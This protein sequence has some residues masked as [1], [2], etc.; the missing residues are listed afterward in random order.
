MATASPLEAD[1]PTVI[2][3][4][5]DFGIG[6]ETS[7]GIV[8]AHLQGPVTCTSVM[9]T[10]PDALAAST[11][12]LA[13][14]PRLELGLHFVCSGGG[15]R[16]LVA[17]RASGFVG[18][19]GAFLGLATL[20]GRVLAGRVDSAAAEDEMAAQTA[21]FVGAIGR[22]PAYVDGHHHAHQLGPMA[23]A[24]VR[25]VAKGALPPRSRLTREEGKGVGPGLKRRIARRWA[26]GA[27]PLFAAQGVA[28]NDHF[29]GML[30]STDLLRGNP[31]GRQIDAVR[32]LPASAGRVV[33]WVVHPGEP[34]ESLRGVDPYVEGRPLELNALIGGQQTGLWDGLNLVGK[35]VA[36]AK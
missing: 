10:R 20:W 22:P 34:D 6:L 28:V 29:F 27:G 12:L 33:E 21:V 35:C 25:L 1:R 9:T 19:D 7:R 23:K 36:L 11:Q 13:E 14:C 32:K 24:L 5:D 15:N 3:T 31:W 26:A 17:T 8:S 2:C 30:I 4:A 16:P 18:R